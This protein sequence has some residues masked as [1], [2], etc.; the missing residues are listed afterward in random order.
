MPLLLEWTALTVLKIHSLSIGGAHSRV[1]A[2]ITI[3]PPLPIMS[4]NNSWLCST[5]KH[6]SALLCTQRSTNNILRILVKAQ[7]VLNA[8]GHGYLLGL[9]YDRKTWAY[10][11]NTLLATVAFL[12]SLHTNLLSQAGYSQLLTLQHSTKLLCKKKKKKKKKS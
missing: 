11:A 9:A 12:L 4:L 5:H 3:A 6:C 7:T 2:S 1:E 8:P 10:S